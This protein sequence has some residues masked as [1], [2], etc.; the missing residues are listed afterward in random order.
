VVARMEWGAAEARRAHKVAARA[1]AR[2]MEEAATGET[3]MAEAAMGA[4]PTAP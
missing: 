4:V 2:P 3:P 1:M